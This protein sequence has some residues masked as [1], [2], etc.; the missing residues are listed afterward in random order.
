[1]VLQPGA[2][3]WLATLVWETLK[4]YGTLHL[5]GSSPSLIFKISTSNEAFR[6]F[7]TTYPKPQ[8]HPPSLD[9]HFESLSE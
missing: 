8:T 2:G 1:M 5:N 3:L 4:N 9:A 6:A 7:Q